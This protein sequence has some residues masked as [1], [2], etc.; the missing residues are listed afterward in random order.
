MAQRS[1]AGDVI[2][3]VVDDD[4]E[5]D[6]CSDSDSDLDGYLNDDEM[7]ELIRRK[8]CVCNSEEGSNDNERADCDNTMIGDEHEVDDTMI[9][10]EHEVDEHEVDKMM[11]DDDVNSMMMDRAMDMD[12]DV[13]DYA[14][15]HYEDEHNCLD[16]VVDGNAEHEP[17]AENASDTSDISCNT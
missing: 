16:E 13:M 8:E 7:T 3:L 15:E 2:Q 12:Y 9:G 6:G 14:N 11:I 1:K 17:Q 5:S 4:D 10:D